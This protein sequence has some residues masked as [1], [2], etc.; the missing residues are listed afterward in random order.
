MSTIAILLAAAG[1]LVV[2]AGTGIALARWACNAEYQATLPL[3]PGVT[4]PPR[5]RYQPMP[6]RMRNGP[7]PPASPAP[8]PPKWH[9][10]PRC[11]TNHS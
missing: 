11:G 1:F 10:C 8:P 5:A 9:Q 4:W 3:P 7:R 6:D 2:T